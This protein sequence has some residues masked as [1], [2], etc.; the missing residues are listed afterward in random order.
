LDFGA[1]DDWVRL[2][3]ENSKFSQSLD[4][5]DNGLRKGASG[6]L[7]YSGMTPLM[8]WQ[9]K[10]HAVG[11]V[12]HIMDIAKS[13]KESPLFSENRLAWMGM[14]KQDFSE[15]QGALKRYEAAGKDTMWDKL[16]KN[17]PELYSKMMTAVQRESRRVVQENDLA[18]AIPI[19]G[20]GAAQTFFQFQNFTFQAWNKSMLHAYHQR[21]SVAFLQM[22]Y[23]VMLSSLAYTARSNL[24]SLGM[25]AEKQQEFLDKKLDPRAI[26]VAGGLMR[27]PQVSMLPN[28]IG[29]FA[30]M[31]WLQGAKTTSDVT[32]IFSSPT[33]QTISAVGGLIKDPIRAAYDDEYQISQKDIRNYSR[34]IPFNNFLGMSAIGNAI[35]QDFPGSNVE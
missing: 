2:R 4:A 11:M 30:P 22:T 19:M 12:N 16:Q 35:G 17:N 21:D 23:G 26:F 31:E 3:G 7:K 15:L 5:L 24:Q 20:H 1:S 32:S 28:L 34:L 10:V 27:I 13:G 18:S 6:L 9:K 29:T 14:T 8:L 33:L 25:D